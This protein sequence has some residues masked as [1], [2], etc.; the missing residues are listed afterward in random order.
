MTFRF[1]LE[2]ST[3]PTR[4]PARSISQA[5]SV[6]WASTSR[7]RPAPVPRPRGGRPAASAP[8]T[9]RFAPA[10]RHHAVPHALDGVGHR[11]GGDR[12]VDRLVAFERP[13]RGLR[14]LRPSGAGAPRRGPAPDPGL[15]PP[16]PPRAP[17][18]QTPSAR[19][20]LARRSCPPARPAPA[21]SATTIC[22]IAA[23][24][25]RAS[26]LHCTSGRP[27]SSTSAFGAPAPK[28]SPLPAARIRAM[29]IGLGN[30][31][32]R[33]RRL[34]AVAAACVKV[35]LPAATRP[36]RRPSGWWPSWRAARRG[37]SR[38]LP[39]PCRAHT[40]ALRRGSS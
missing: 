36:R 34:A 20:A 4:P 28:R 29:G 21:G 17:G 1:S 12:P 2:D 27:A 38:P 16:R 37:S 39:R 3:T 30:P 33:G 26:T 14:E 24:A 32:A 19:A 35:S 23:T 11:H 8:P 15:A 5:S 9:A 7:A 25:R 31:R 40:S 18:A 22:S 10:S 6:A 13:D